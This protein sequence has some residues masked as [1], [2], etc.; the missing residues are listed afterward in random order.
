MD[1]TEWTQGTVMTEDDAIFV[2][3]FLKLLKRL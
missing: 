1:K 2:L 3:P